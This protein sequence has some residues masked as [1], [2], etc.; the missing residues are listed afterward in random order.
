MINCPFASYC[1][2]NQNL[3]VTHWKGIA[4]FEKQSDREKIILVE[5]SILFY[6][7]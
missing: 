6:K 2:H 3:N 1:I 4:L 7:L 5:H